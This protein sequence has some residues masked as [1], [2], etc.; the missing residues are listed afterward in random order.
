MHY[1]YIIY[2]KKIDRYYIGESENVVKRLKQ[3]NSHYFKNAF[4]TA[5]SDWEIKLA[6]PCETKLIAKKLERH[7]KKKK[8]R[9]HIEWIISSKDALDRMLLQCNE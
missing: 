6:Y 9:K 3:H 8:S 5:A 1:F 7:I 2:S 4:T